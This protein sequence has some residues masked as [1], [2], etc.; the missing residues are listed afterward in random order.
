MTILYYILT[1]IASSIATL[2]VPDMVVRY[3]HSKTRK[4]QQLQALIATEVAKQLKD[5]IND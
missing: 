3:R 1:V 2:I 4:Q 5:I